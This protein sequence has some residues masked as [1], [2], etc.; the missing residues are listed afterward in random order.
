MN[1]FLIG[2]LAYATFSICDASAKYLGP[3]LSVFEIGFFFNVF[4]AIVLSVTRHAQERWRDF[5]RM[6]RP[7]LVHGRA[8]FGVMASMCAV[9]AFTRIP[10]A[11]AYALIFLAPLIVTMLSAL[12]LKEHVGIWRWSAVALGFIGVLFVVRPGFQ[13]LHLGHLGAVGCALGTGG[14]VL[15]LRRMAGGAKKTSILGTLVLYLIALNGAAMLAT[16]SFV[17]PTAFQFAVLALG[18]LCYGLGQWALVIALR[19]GNASQIAPAH[20]S[21]LLCAV[22]FGA[23]IFGEFPDLLALVGLAIIAAAGLLTVVRERIRHGKAARPVI[24]SAGAVE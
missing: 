8:M 5:W 16:D 20:Y 13:E 3:H 15:L 4:A 12:L 6:D 23:V 14:A 7:L 9:F 17:M 1:P 24:Q 2:L 22:V 19:M 18:G 10:L 11:E 21:Q